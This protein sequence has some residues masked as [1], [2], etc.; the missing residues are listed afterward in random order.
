MEKPVLDQTSA[1]Q[2]LVYRGRE[3]FHTSKSEWNLTDEDIMAISQVGG[4]ENLSKPKR[5]WAE[6]YAGTAIR[7][8]QKEAN[9]LEAQLN[10]PAKLGEVGAMITE[11]VYGK[12]GLR[13]EL[14]GWQDVLTRYTYLLMKTLEEKGIITKED[15]DK[16]REEMGEKLSEAIKGARGLTED[17]PDPPESKEQ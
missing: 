12:D 3:L 10:A 17:V 13:D 9:E 1:T 14:K 5:Y 2:E 8:Q 11:V 6:K 4:I 16:T 7:A 15:M